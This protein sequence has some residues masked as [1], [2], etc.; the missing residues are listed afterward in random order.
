MN[1]LSKEELSALLAA[2]TIICFTVGYIVTVR[3]FIS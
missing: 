1:H 2:I 3:A